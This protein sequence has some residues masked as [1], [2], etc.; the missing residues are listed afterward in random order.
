MFEKRPELVIALPLKRLSGSGRLQSVLDLRDAETERKRDLTMSETLF[1]S[2]LTFLNLPLSTDFAAA[3]VAILGIPF[4]CARDLIRFGSRQGPNAVR[5]A[6]VLTGKL[7]KDASPSPLERLNVVDA[8]NVN[9]S[10]ED[11]NQAFAQIEKA[12][13]AIVQQ[14]CI[15]LTIGGDGAVSLP[16]MR[17]LHK[18]FGQFAVIHIDAHTDAWP[19][20]IDNPFT[21][22]N[23]FTHAVTE[24]LI[25][26]GSAL[27]IGT[28][29]PVNANAAIQHA[30]DMGYEVIPIEQYFD[31]GVTSIVEH[32]LNRIG[33]MPVFICYDMDFFDPAMVPGVATPTPGGATPAEGIALMRGMR[34]LNIIGIDINTT[35]PVHDPAGSSA[36]LAAT[37][38]AEGLGILPDGNS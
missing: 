24:G 35:T 26:V 36:N 25:D 14:D 8:G 30:R 22:A 6:S 20:A 1:E 28:R 33:D 21:N 37:L 12:M 18:R 4:D 15:P 32:I 16:Q 19:V 5:H 3:D 10:Q 7:I 29:G 2:P 9:L 34:G 31:M 27:H 11:I 23:Q 17:A 38:L 13:T